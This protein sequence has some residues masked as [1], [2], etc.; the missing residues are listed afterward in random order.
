M[1]S[2]VL[3]IIVLA[4]QL[5]VT[6]GSGI[7]AAEVSVLQRSDGTTGTITQLGD[8]VGFYSDAHGNTGPVIMPGGPAP[9][10]SGP[11][12]DPVTGRMIPFGAPMPPSNLTPSPVL[13]F[14]PNQPLAPQQPPPPSAAPPG[15]G[16]SDGG[17]FGR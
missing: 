2:F 15:F 11:H 9:S 14:R 17:R 5:L 12:G 8:N 7:A 16:F 4:A 3:I 13:P 1:T 6:G 10:L